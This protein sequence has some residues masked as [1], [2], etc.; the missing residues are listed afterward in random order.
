M[1]Q[2]ILGIGHKA[3]HGKDTFARAI[4]DYY[5]NLNA[6]ALKHGHGKPV[7]VQRLAFADALRKEANEWLAT[8]EGKRFRGLG[9]ILLHKH[10]TVE[11]G[12][13]RDN[14]SPGGIYL[15][16][17]GNPPVILPDW[18]E[19]DPNPEVTPQTPLGKHPKLLQ[20]WGTEYRRS[21]DQDYWVKKGL[22][23]ISPTAD[24]VI[25][26]D[27][28]FYNEAWGI[29]Q[30]GGYTVNLTRLNADGKSF[31]DPSRPANHISETQLDDFNYDFYLKSK[32]AV[33]TGEMAVTLV[34]YLIA[35]AKKGK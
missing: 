29:I 8:S 7:V 14:I 6:A 34:H 19:R 18:V 2:I 15:G 16:Q 23:R 25:F 9:G 20:W 11:E 28:R 30:R 1:T 21:Q 10:Y 17:T 13:L 4:E 12:D 24:I 33:L 5:G 22:E 32:D 26:T 31:V 3:R 35:R 27:M